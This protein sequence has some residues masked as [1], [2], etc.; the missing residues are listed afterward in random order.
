MYDYDRRASEDEDEPHDPSNGVL[1]KWQLDSLQDKH[2]WKGYQFS[3]TTW[4]WAAEVYEDQDEPDDWGD[5]SK[6]GPTMTLDEVLE[7]IDKAPFKWSKWSGSEG[8]SF[9]STVKKTK[10]IVTQGLAEIERLDGKLLSYEER[11]HITRTLKLKR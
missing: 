2:A 9:E 4:T 6:Q 3:V 5:S 11:Q 10:K 8:G 1:H 7:A